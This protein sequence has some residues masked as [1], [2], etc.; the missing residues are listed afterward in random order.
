[1]SLGGSV[2]DSVRISLAKVSSCD[3]L[4]QFIS[5]QLY[6]KAEVHVSRTFHASWSFEGEVSL[7]N[8]VKDW[9]S[10]KQF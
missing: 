9:A 4:C 6:V 2:D 10:R 1:M 8:N 7:N 5:T 3:I